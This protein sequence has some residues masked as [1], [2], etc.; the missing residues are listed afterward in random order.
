MASIPD[1]RGDWSWAC[2]PRCRTRLLVA[3][4]SSSDAESYSLRRL[5]TVCG[6]SSALAH[7]VGEHASL[8]RA[9]AAF[10]SDVA[11]VW[12]VVDLGSTHG[13]FLNSRRLAPLTREA[14]RVGDT[15]TLGES[16][17]QYILQE[18]EEAAGESAQVVGGAAVESRAAERSRHE[19]EIAA[20]IASF[21]APP[22]VFSR[23]PDAAVV[24][25][26]VIMG[27][28]GA[29]SGVG[30]EADGGGAAEADDDNDDDDDEYGIVEYDNIPMKED[31][32]STGVWAGSAVGAAPPLPSAQY[33]VRSVTD[34]R[35]R[36]PDAAADDD[37]SSA[38]LPISGEL[39]LAGHVRSCT[40]VAADPSGARFATGSV[41]STVRIFDFG[42]MD[43]AAR[44]YCVVT[45]TDGQPVNALAWASDGARLAVGTGMAKVRVFSRDGVSEVT[46]VAGDA[47][48][49]DQT[50]TK[51]HR[52]G[53]TG[54]AF[55]PTAPAT[56]FSASLDGTVRTWDLVGGK[57]AFRELC[58]GDVM[59]FRATSGQRVGV[60]AFALSPDGK[61][62][63]AGLSDGSVQYVGVR[64]PGHR[65]A[66]A[67]GSARNAHS[68]S[69]TAVAFS[70]SGT[71]FAS[72][73]LDGRVAIWDVRRFGGGGTSGGGQPVAS[74]EGLSTDDEHAGVAWS[75]DSS[76]IVIGTSVK[77]VRGG[78][79]ASGAVTPASLVFLDVGVAGSKTTTTSLSVKSTHPLGTVH[80]SALAVTWHTRLNQI[81][82]TAADGS[83]RVLFDLHAAS[84]KGAVGAA[85]RGCGRAGAGGADASADDDFFPT[86]DMIIAPLA[87]EAE[88]R[89]AKKGGAGRGGG[90]G[91]HDG[92]G[93]AGRA[94]VNPPKVLS[95]HP[96]FT[97]NTFADAFLKSCVP[98]YK[99]LIAPTPISW[100]SP[101][102][103]PP[104]PQTHADTRRFCARMCERKTPKLYSLR[105]RASRAAT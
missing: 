78:G 105:M 26:S 15:V 55:A 88:A 85:L 9:H 52:G 46:T 35:G 47:Y 59:K 18:E 6:R 68:S 20:A 97:K 73:A 57:T 53:V 44:P 98:R 22:R 89:R 77:R 87:L 71:L 27:G 24:N 50:H 40:A 93:A 42:G 80:A 94:P 65:Y 90:G 17:R 32:F 95:K 16:T 76:C 79:G 92:D 70:P 104:P 72:R 61:L 63:I 21:G 84:K 81:F 31:Q 86:E 103:P 30:A 51:G 45:P 13:T 75:P 28:A 60:S 91:D 74:F 58:C 82:V 48:V 36:A 4:P 43:I 5:V 1:P 23:E 11:G 8:S 66:W 33:D 49:M 62:V 99:F 102:P 96:A 3:R 83:A 2:I 7:V 37:G 54:V 25:A 19:A 64:A 12:Y 39:V 56:L 29:V 34:G 67:D 100:H 10:A 14:V 38:A 69:V 101:T 41:D